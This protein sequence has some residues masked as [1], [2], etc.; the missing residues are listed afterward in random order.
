MFFK[1]AHFTIFPN[2]QKNIYTNQ[3]RLIFYKYPMVT[4]ILVGRRWEI[5][6]S[7]CL[8]SSSKINWTIRLKL[9]INFDFFLNHSH[10]VFMQKKS[11]FLV[12][13]SED[14]CFFF[15]ELYR[16]F[17]KNGRVESER[18]EL[19]HLL[20]FIKIFYYGLAK[21]SFTRMNIL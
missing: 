9:I 16:T 20:L 11:Y 13:Y 4:I 1:I 14:L 17:V 21:K 12:D 3:Y 15:M 8:I 19:I 2:P 10:R 6:R 7:G 18:R 5:K